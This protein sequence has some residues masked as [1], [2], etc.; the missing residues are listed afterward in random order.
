MYSDCHNLLYFCFIFIRRRKHVRKEFQHVY[1]GLVNQT[2]IVPLLT[3]SSNSVISCLIWLCF[4]IKIWLCNVYSVTA[5][6]HHRRTHFPAHTK[7]TM[8]HFISCKTY[9]QQYLIPQTHIVL[10]WRIHPDCCITEDLLQERDCWQWSF[11]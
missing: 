4:Y 7:L 2:L 8:S 11:N 1:T 9:Q 10:Q 5:C 3:Y 6:I